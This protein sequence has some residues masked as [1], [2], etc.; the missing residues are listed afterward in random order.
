PAEVAELPRRVR[1]ASLV[2]QLRE[3]RAPQAA[4]VAASAR[5]AGRSPEEARE[6]MAAYRA[7]WARG[8]EDGSTRAASEGEEG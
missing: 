3:V 4:P 2:P 6:Q 1:Q 8:A 5:P 7:G